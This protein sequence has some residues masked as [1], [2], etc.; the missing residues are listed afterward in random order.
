MK[1]DTHHENDAVAVCI[2]CGKKICRDCDFVCANKHYCEDC[3]ENPVKEKEIQILEKKK[4][5]QSKI[6]IVLIT[7]V[8]WGSITA[9]AT[10]VFV[11]ILVFALSTPSSYGGFNASIVA[12]FG[13]P[14]LIFVVIFILIFLKNEKYGE[15]ERFN[16]LD[17][18]NPL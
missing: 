16:R 5:K 1:C 9:F 11:L 15:K 6:D 17:L 7:L 12:L 4:S 2:S 14:W 3:K 13:V 8:V 18:D 10:L